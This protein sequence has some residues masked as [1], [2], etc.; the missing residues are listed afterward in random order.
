MPKN[1]GQ[2]ELVER[3]PVRKKIT[4]DPVEFTRNPAI[5]PCVIT[6]NGRSRADTGFSPTQFEYGRTSIP[7]PSGNYSGSTSS[8]GGRPGGGTG[9]C[10]GETR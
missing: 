4:P 10:G 1:P 3:I 9:W 2:E 5:K 7:E 6:G 8:A